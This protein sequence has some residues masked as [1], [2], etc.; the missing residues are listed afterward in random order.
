MTWSSASPAPDQALHRLLGAEL[1]ELAM[2]RAL[3]V[4]DGE[5]G[6]QELPDVAQGQTDPLGAVV[7]PDDSPHEQ[8]PLSHYILN[9]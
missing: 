5:R 7:N 9:G 1:L 8:D 2:E 3:A 6:R 4:N